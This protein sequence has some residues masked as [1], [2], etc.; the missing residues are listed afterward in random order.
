MVA[1]RLV[2]TDPRVLLAEWAN[3][4]DEWVRFLVAE[5]ISTGRAR[6]DSTIE[7]AYQLFRQEKSIDRRELPLLGF[8]HRSSTR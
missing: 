2:V 5:V 8:E 7:M 4:N 1:R 3:Q 6:S